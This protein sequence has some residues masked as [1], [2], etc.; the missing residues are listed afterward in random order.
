MKHKKSIQTRDM[1]Y[2]ALGIAALISGGFIIYQA[3]LFIAMPGVKYILMA[4]YLSM[5]MYILTAK[6]SVRFPVLTIGTIFGLIMMFMNLFMVAAILMTSVL[7]EVSTFYMGRKESRNFIGAV[8]FSTY[9]GLSA[10]VIS[11]YAIGG[12]FASMPIE[13]IA[14]TAILCSVFGFAGTKLGQKI[15]RYVNLY[16]IGT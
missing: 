3:S 11:K 10:L 6:V 8:L 4:P 16:H 9:T 1:T 2:I 12:V 15:L 13:W 14:Y 5:I 7:T